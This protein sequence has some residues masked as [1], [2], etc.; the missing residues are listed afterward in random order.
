MSI[1]ILAVLIIVLIGLRTLA[2]SSAAAAVESG[3]PARAIGLLEAGRSILWQQT[4]TP[5]TT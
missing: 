2:A 1:W 3:D 4:S 5:A